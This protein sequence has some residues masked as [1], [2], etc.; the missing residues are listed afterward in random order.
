MCQKLNCIISSCSCCSTCNCKLSC[1]DVRNQKYSCTNRAEHNSA[2]VRYKFVC[3]P[4]RRIWKSY[5][6]KYLFNIANKTNDDFSQYVPNI[7]KP[8]MTKHEKKCKT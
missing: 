7:C 3:F 2:D 1:Y 5:T 4:C 6:N 8:E